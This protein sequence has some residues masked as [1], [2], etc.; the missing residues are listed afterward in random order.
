MEFFDYRPDVLEALA[1][2]GVRPYRSTHPRFVRDYLNDLYRYELRQL[3]D[4]LLRGRFPK[5]ELA[6]RVV[7]LRK[8][9]ALLSRPIADWTA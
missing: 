1:R 8:R 7:E 3:R 4:G 6:G 9:Y 5:R 2:H